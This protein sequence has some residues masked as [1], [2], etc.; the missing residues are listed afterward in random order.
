M[1]RKNF[2]K[3]VFAI[4]SI[5][6]IFLITTILEHKKILTYGLENQTKRIG[7]LKPVVLLVEFPDLKSNFEISTPEFYKKILFEKN[8]KS[9]YDYFYENSQGKLE[10][11][12]TIYQ[13]DESLTRWFMAP[14]EYKFYENNSYG[15]GKYPNNTQ[16]LVEDIIEIVDEHVDF[17]NHDGNNDGFV[18]CVIIIYAGSYI[19]D[20]ENTKIYPHSWILNK[21]IK[22]DNK[23][24]SKYMVISEYKYNP[25]DFTIGPLCHEL[26]HILGGIDLY[27]LDSFKNFTFD[28]H[29]SNGVGKWSLMSHGIWGK[30]KIKGDTPSHFD[31]WHKIHFGWLDP[32]VIKDKEIII[33]LDPIETKSG[34]VLKINL[35]ENQSEYLLIENRQKIGFDLCLPNE[36]II[37]YHVDESMPNNSYAYSPYYETPNIKHYKVS[38]IQKDNL[39][40][41]E[42]GINTGDEN[43]SFNVGDKFIFNQDEKHF[44]YYNRN[45]KIFISILEKQNNSYIL[46]I[47]IF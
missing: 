12:G 40:E 17:S 1:V 16:K 7:T 28:K 26:G 22:K 37:I 5:T 10:I 6:I 24:I 19:S 25:H 13:N 31:A 8:N 45:I 30:E 38:V 29:I 42:R 47:K 11:I 15:M 21:S 43:D 14:R 41:L 27:D 33:K 36:G 23:Y 32:I 18:D 4:I 39:F 46:K 35:N 34:Q 44:S 2:K 3:S 9:L 20:N